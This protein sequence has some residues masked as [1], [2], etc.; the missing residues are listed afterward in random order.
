MPFYLTHKIIMQ[1]I[2]ELA[3]A[4]ML[5][6]V[7]VLGHSSNNPPS[8]QCN[9][10]HHASAQ[11]FYKNSSLPTWNTNTTLFD[12][13][14]YNVKYRRACKGNHVIT[15]TGLR[16]LFQQPTKL[17]VQSLPSCISSNLLPNS[18]IPIWNTKLPTWIHF[19]LHIKGILF[20]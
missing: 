19:F 10:Y 12:P 9:H 1:N 14:N 6:L 17:P 15:S 5:L 16:E 8:F 11:T 3:K 7:Q 20:L 18:S 4:T 13:Q 2:E